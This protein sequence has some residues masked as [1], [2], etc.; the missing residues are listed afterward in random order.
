M[1]TPSTKLAVTA[2]IVVLAVAT[3]AVVLIN[4]PGGSNG[5][6]T[7]GIN[8]IEIIGNTTDILYPELMDATF[9][10]VEGQWQVQANF[11]DDSE[12][13]E[14]PETY[15]RTFPVAAHEVDSIDDA[16]VSS[17]NRTVQSQGNLTAIL[18]SGAHIGFCMVVT[19]NDGGW[20]SIWVLQIE[21]GQF[22]YS[23]GVG[24]PNTN[25]L[26]ASLREPVS[27]LDDL[28]NAVHTVFSNNL[29]D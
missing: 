3:S 13:W 16:L 20:I 23:T 21:S 22:L 8:R 18:L 24:T 28:V 26:D 9:A 25:M 14:S 17:F 11:V 2:T 29:N 6:N 10:I 5:A 27:A 1:D 12:G 4:L 19:Y 7:S 15:D